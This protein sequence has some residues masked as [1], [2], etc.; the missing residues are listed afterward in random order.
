MKNFN[1]L[2]R[3]R[4]G[5]GNT[6]Y[7]WLPLFSE[8]KIIPKPIK[9]SAKLQVVNFLNDLY[10]CFDSI[11][12]SYDVY[13][14]M[15]NAII[16][17]INIITNNIIVISNDLLVITIIITIT[18]LDSYNISYTITII[19]VTKVIIMMIVQHP[20]HQVETIGDAYMVV[21][22]LP[23]RNDIQHAGE[24]ASLAL[25]VLSKMSTNTK[26]SHPIS[27]INIKS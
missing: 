24:I 4:L 14:V 3:K 11:I 27:K 13:K 19:I 1:F 2:V 25:Q 10:T 12:D 21:S 6:L 23:V 22:G 17:I 18:I 15:F 5:L 9:V 20:H 26:T 16:I 8:T 7:L